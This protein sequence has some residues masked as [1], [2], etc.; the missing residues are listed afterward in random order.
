MC[1][2]RLLFLAASL[3]FT[4]ALAAC[5]EAS[6]DSDIEGLESNYTSEAGEPDAAPAAPTVV[7]VPAFT[8]DDA[9]DPKAKLRFS[10]NGSVPVDAFQTE[11]KTLVSGSDRRFR[12]Q[13]GTPGVE[14]ARPVFYMELGRGP[15]LIEK[16]TYDCANKEAVVLVIDAEGK[17]N[18]TLVDGG[19]Q[20]ACKVVIDDLRVVEPSSAAVA[21]PYRQIIGH[22][23]AEVAPREDASAPTKIVRAT[24]AA[25]VFEQ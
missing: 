12:L 16:T 5:G 13:G 8:L 23:E 19:P 6:S 20:R 14:S 2:R 3:P 9:R 21:K 22:V 18:M 10:Y 7:D 15:A 4:F 24:F 25:T 17:K 1:P 11:W